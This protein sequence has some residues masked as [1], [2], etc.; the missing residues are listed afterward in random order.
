MEFVIVTTTLNSDDVLEAFLA[1]HQ[2]LGATR[3]YVMDMGSSDGTLDTL[4]SERWKGIIHLLPTSKDEADPSNLTLSLVKTLEPDAWCLF[5]DPDEFVTPA[6]RSVELSATVSAVEL[7][8]YNLTALAGEIRSDGEVP[9]AAFRYE[10]V[11]PTERTESDFTAD[12]LQPPWIFSKVHKKVL[13]KVA[14]A[15][16]IEAG[17]H[18]AA[19]H[20]GS[21]IRHP[22]L[23]MRH[24]PFRSQKKFEQKV[25]DI[26]GFFRRNP[27]LPPGWGWHWRRWLRIQ[28]AGDLETE[29][30]RQFLSER[31]ARTL[32][33][34]GTVRMLDPAESIS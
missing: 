12:E 15:R 26:R 4:A 2:N 6:I 8:R 30:R 22:Q 31:D 20:S 25:F 11:R 3:F 28:D 7:P 27:S 18:A 23:H 13:V 16:R 34:A 21:S 29:Y 24:I 14:H 10:I 32:V 5:C 19:L 9:L 1:H 33:D 17:D